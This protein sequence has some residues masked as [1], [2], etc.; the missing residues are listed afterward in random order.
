MHD[1]AERVTFTR[2]P[3]DEELA[4]VVLLTADD[5]VLGLLD[6]ARVA[7]AVKLWRL[8]VFGAVHYRAGAWLPADRA[9]LAHVADALGGFAPAALEMLSRADSA[10]VTA[11]RDPSVP[12]AALDARSSARRRFA[13]P[14]A[15]LPARSGRIL[16]REAPLRFAA[17]TW[18]AGSPLG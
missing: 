17:A 9:A 13:T 5:W 12:D 1:D 16:A 8:A 7:I 3:I 18:F 11:I 2:R 10:L 14:A 15:L 4:A 6:A